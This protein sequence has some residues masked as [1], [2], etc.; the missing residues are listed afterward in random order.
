MIKLVTKPRDR[1]GPVVSGDMVEV[2]D[3]DVFVAGVY[4]HQGGVR[5]VS[6]YLGDVRHEPSPPPAVVIAFTLRK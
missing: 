4:P 1:F 6:K 2:W 3:D 5:V